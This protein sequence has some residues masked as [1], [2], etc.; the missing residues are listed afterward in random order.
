MVQNQTAF[1]VAEVEVS[2]QHWLMGSITFTLKHKLKKADINTL[3]QP[4]NQL[5]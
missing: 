5:K 1:K 4:P 2:Y 3:L